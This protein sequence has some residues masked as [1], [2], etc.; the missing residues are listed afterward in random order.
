VTCWRILAGPE[1]TLQYTQNARRELAIWTADR[2]GKM[3]RG[4]V[5]LLYGT[6]RLQEYVAVARACCDPVQNDRAQRLRKNREWWTYLQ[7][8]PLHTPLPRERIQSEDFA[9]IDGSG[10]NTPSGSRSNRVS[11]AAFDGFQSVLAGHDRR[12]ADQLSKWRSGG[13]RYPRSLDIEELRW[14][15]WEAPAARKQEE[16]LLSQRIAAR[17][18]KTRGVRYLTPG[19]RPETSVGPVRSLEHPIQDAAGAGRVDVVLVDDRLET[20][21]LLAIEVK[22]RASLA[23]GRNPIPQAIRYRAALELAYGAG[24]TVRPLIVAEHFHVAVL[25]DAEA[26]GLEHRICKR[27]GKLDQ[28]V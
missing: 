14:A 16:L 11:D 24:W 5:V 18:V 9:Q 15:E 13:G 1:S 26:K 3:R 10:L 8:Q 28:P 2:S 6:K 27:S 12:A 19:D 20:P 4:D 7:V 17:L 25:E 21:T 22:L 23:P